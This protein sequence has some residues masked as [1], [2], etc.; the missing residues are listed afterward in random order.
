MRTCGLFV[1]PRLR[2]GRRLFRLALGRFGS[3]FRIR[4]EG[5]R[6]YDIRQDESSREELVRQ[7]TCALAVLR[8]TCPKWLRFLQSNDVV[9]LLVTGRGAWYNPMT[10]SIALGTEMVLEESSEDVARVLVHETAHARISRHSRATT[11]NAVRLERACLAREL[12]YLQRL[13]VINPNVDMPAQ[14]AK[15]RAAWRDPVMMGERK[16]RQFEGHLLSTGLPHWVRT[17]ISIGKTHQT[18]A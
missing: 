1:L 10:D 16:R 3:G 11:A 13:A 18:S 9:V 2:F 7:L 4:I 15:W 8:L 12:E 17:V 6:V 14:L 5:C